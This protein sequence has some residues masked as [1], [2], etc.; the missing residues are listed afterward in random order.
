VTLKRQGWKEGKDLPADLDG[1]EGLPGETVY[2]MQGKGGR[3]GD[4][5]ENSHCWN[6]SLD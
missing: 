3:Q 4:V 1:D 6:G 5:T 2:P